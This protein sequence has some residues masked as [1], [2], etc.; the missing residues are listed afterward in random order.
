MAN[1]CIGGIVQIA[2]HG[3]V[4]QGRLTSL[5]PCD[6]PSSTNLRAIDTTLKQRAQK[7][8]ESHGSGLG[9]KKGWPLV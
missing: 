4:P 9:Y 2:K 3:R 7:S 5:V 6:T 1:Q 8:M